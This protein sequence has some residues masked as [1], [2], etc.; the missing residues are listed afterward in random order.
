MAGS[1]SASGQVNGPFHVKRR[2]AGDGYPVTSELASQNATACRELAGFQCLLAELFSPVG[3]QHAVDGAGYRILIDTRSG[4]E[5]TAGE[6]AL[7][8]WRGNDQSLIAQVCQQ[9]QVRCCF[10][11]CSF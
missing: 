8:S 2:L 9:S 11:H 10:D 7:S 5:V 6:I 3:H 1:I 4:G